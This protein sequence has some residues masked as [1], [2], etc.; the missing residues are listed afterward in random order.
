[1]RRSRSGEKQSWWAFFPS[2]AAD[3]GICLSPTCT[4][5][6]TQ[7]RGGFGRLGVVL[8]GR[9]ILS[10]PAPGS[11]MGRMGGNWHPM[12]ESRERGL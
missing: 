2:P 9:S 12:D 3:S 11:D 10:Q 4:A 1:M 7:S 8:L 6:P 5:S